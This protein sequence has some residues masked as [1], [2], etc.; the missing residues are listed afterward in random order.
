LLVTPGTGIGGIAISPD[1]AHIAVMARM[2][3]STAQ[4]ETWEI[5]APLPG[6]PRK[7]L[8]DFVGVRWS[9]DGRR[10]VFIRAGGSAGDA[11]F[12]AD[13]DGTNQREIIKLGGGVHIHWPIWSADGFIYFI[14]TIQN[15]VN[16]EPAEIYRVNPDR[17]TIEPFVQTSRRA[18][19]PL[20]LPG[21]DGL[22]YSANPLSADLGLWWSAPDGRSTHELTNGVGE[23]AE[24]RISAD[25]RTL[26]CTVYDVRQSLVSIDAASGAT[27]SITSGQNRD[28]DPSVDNVGKRLVFSSARTGSRLLWTSGLD[29]SNA[30]PLTSG[31]A[32]DERPSIS[33][34]GKL[35][36]FVSDR[37]RRRAIWLINPDGGAPH[38]LV[39]V[40]IVGGLAW[41]RDSRELTFSAA[42]GSWPAL[43][44][45]SVPEGRLRQ[46]FTLKAEAVGE[47]APSPTTDVIAYAAATTTGPP[48]ARVGFVDSKGN[49]AY[50]MLPPPASEL[51]TSGGLGGNGVLAWSPDGKRLAVVNQSGSGAPSVWIVEPDASNPYKKLTEFSGGP[52]IR[53]I[54]WTPDGRSI[55]VGK[56]DTSSSDIVV[57]QR[58]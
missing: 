51:S 46:V 5:P 9:P 55:V 8:A 24:P 12:V 25:G 48:L 3:G 37:E 4:N 1:G 44:A 14:R 35:I 31:N 30:R 15:L 22:I 57:F 27:S 11:L 42:T 28:L 52:R 23:Y 53:G 32:L 45:V 7:L 36:A 21:G 49:P 39:D 43:T 47:S 29:G 16:M 40:D 38:K 50:P 26:V 6:A 17:G 54:A 10:L 19:F 18:I 41:S 2:T 58:P 56:H 33:P 34:D 13:A 20:P